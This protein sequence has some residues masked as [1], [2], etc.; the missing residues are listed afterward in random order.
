M[1]H[2][3]PRAEQHPQQPTA[4]VAATTLRAPAAKPLAGALAVRA[5]RLLLDYVHRQVAV[6]SGIRPLRDSNKAF[7]VSTQ[8]CVVGWLLAVMASVESGD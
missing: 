5:D 6:I 3:R 1:F 7:T 8:Q 2:R 4:P